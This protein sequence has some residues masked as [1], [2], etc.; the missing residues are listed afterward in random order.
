[1]ANRAVRRRYVAVVGVEVAELVVGAAVLALNGLT[2]W[3][4]VWV[5]AV[6]GAHFV[7]LA[8]IFGEPSLTVLGV[9]LGAVA[10]A[11]LVLGLSTD[12]APS[13]IVGTDAGLCLLVFAVL[14]VAGK[15]FARK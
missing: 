4:P 9:L 5:C 8:A 10:A 3:A 13:T 2:E 15:H 6:V 12:A 14:A 7:P 1:M 11:G